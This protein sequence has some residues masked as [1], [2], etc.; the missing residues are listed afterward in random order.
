M[1]LTFCLLPLATSY[2]YVNFCPNAKKSLI[3]YFQT[4]SIAFTTLKSNF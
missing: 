2:I 3:K 1:F 4:E